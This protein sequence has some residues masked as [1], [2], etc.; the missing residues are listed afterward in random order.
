MKK[1]TVKT[2]AMTLMFVCAAVLSSCS[3]SRDKKD[4]MDCVPA[5]AAFVGMI[6]LSSAW[7]QLGIKSEGDDFTF[8]KEVKDL[9]K[10]AQIPN[11]A[12]D[13]IEGVLKCMEDT[14][15]SIVVFS[16]DKH[17]W[18]TFYVSDGD[19]FIKLM[20]DEAKADFDKEDGYQV[21]EK[22][23][24][25]GNRVWFCD[26]MDTDELNRLLD[27]D[28]D[29]RFENKYEKVTEYLM[30]EDASTSFCMNFSYLKD[31][32][33]QSEAQMLNLAMSFCF[34]DAQFLLY[35]SRLTDAEATSEMRM[36]NSK[37]EPAQFLLPMAKID[38]ASLAKLDN[39]SPLIAAIAINPDLVKKIQA[40]A[41]K[42]GGLSPS[43][44]EIF[45]K[46]G[47]ISGTSGFSFASASDATLILNFNDAKTP[48]EVG[49]TISLS[50]FFQTATAGNSLIVR[51]PGTPASGKGTLPSELVGQYAGIYLN[52]AKDGGKLVKGYDLAKLGKAWVVLGPDGNGVKL[53]STWKVKTP[54]LTVI[55]EAMTIFRGFMDNSIT[56]PGIEEMENITYSSTM[57]ASPADS[58]YVS[59]DY[60]LYEEPVADSV[61]VW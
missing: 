9:I 61:A 23:A 4:L 11:D 58:V 5:D 1:I 36:F 8:A 17:V 20:E 29:R 39:E 44:R 27:L 38:A 33:Q 56:F 19:D 50:S 35:Q 2:L 13:K 26:D 22:V 30:A 10:L 60:S 42:M 31:Y 55:T 47:H 15:K 3:C 6:D 37:K 18:A 57:A 48:A 25:K 28:K 49:Q 46:L 45:E 59:E 32:M 16:V 52:P 40:L 12:M 43:D 41:E 51:L 7:D 34:N 53:S 54:L 14:P 21:W 24:V